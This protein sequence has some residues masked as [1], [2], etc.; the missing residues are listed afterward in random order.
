MQNLNSTDQFLRRPL[1]RRTALRGFAVAG[2]GLGATLVGCSSSS[3]NSKP[4]AEAPPEVTAIRLPQTAA[5]CDSAQFLAEKYLGA[6]GFTDVKFISYQAPK[7]PWVLVSAG[8]A[9]IG[10]D[11]IA[12]AVLRADAGEPLVYLSGFHTGCGFLIGNDSVKS[13]ADLKGKKVGVTGTDILVNN[14]YCGAVAYLGSV[15]LKPSD[16]T[17]G[18]RPAA[19]PQIAQALA[20]GS[21]DGFNLAPPLAQQAHA[22]KTGHVVVDLMNDKPWSDNYCCGVAVNRSFAQRNPVATKRALRALLKASDEAASQP[23]AATHY[24]VDKG[25]RPNYDDVFAAFKDM[26]HNKWREADHEGSARFYLKD[27]QGAGVVKNAADKVIADGVNLSF[28]NE[29]KKAKA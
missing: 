25:Y 13:I 19:V 3:S 5:V 11:F 9:D 8:D 10:V 23:E 2:L 6:E 28:L 4:P 18:A 14:D 20:D 24:V 17:F 15:G 26:T 1:S 29:L 21:F 12:T 27:L 7:T 22:A 16:V